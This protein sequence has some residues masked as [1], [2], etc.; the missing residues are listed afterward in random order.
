MDAGDGRSDCCGDIDGWDCSEGRMGWGGT[1]GWG[2]P[3]WIGS[4]MVCGEKALCEECVVLSVGEVNVDGCCGGKL[5]V[6]DMLVLDEAALEEAPGDM[7]DIEADNGEGAN[8][9]S[10]GD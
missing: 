10:V 2:I 4:C 7:G 3:G 8:G 5:V 9:C 1:W 6:K